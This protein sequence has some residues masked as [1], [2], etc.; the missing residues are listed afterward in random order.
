MIEFQRAIAIADQITAPDRAILVVGSG[1]SDHQQLWA[2][3]V[4]RRAFYYDDWM[5][6][7]HT[8]HAGPYDPRRAARYD[9]RRLAEI[10]T[11]AFLRRHGI[12][13]LVVTGNA[14]RTAARSAD[15]EPLLESG[16]SLYTVR[17]PA[18]I[19]TFGA[20]RPESF[21]LQP[22][23]IAA[24]DAEGGGDDA[25]VRRNWHPRWHAT[26]NGV[27]VAVARTADGY[28]RVP[29][30]HGRVALRLEYAL[31][32]MDRLARGVALVSVA[33]CLILMVR[34]RVPAEPCR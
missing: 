3:V 24:T 5:W 32:P 7:W 20:R 6:Y 27:P 14:R 12:G 4:A 22:H 9:R 34:R 10:F 29:V 16:F 30:P 1:L 2:P 18:S 8:R 28:M 15:L 26:V 19:V 33:A 25:I 13:T 17:A 21:S 11:A 23:L 31:L